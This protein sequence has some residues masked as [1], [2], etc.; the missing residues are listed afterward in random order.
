MMLAWGLA[1]GV[2]HAAPLQYQ[3]A[4]ASTIYLG[5][6]AGQD[7]GR[8]L[9]SGDLDGDGY[10]EVIVGASEGRCAQSRIRGAGRPGNARAGHR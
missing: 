9:A 6:I 4:E 1:A 7:W 8:P 5:A 2:G 3:S 10:D